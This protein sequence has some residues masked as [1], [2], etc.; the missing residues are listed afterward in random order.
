[1]PFEKGL[2]T[3]LIILERPTMLDICQVIKQ[4]GVGREQ[5]RYTCQAHAF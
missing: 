5:W 3:I 4:S 1:M 2:I